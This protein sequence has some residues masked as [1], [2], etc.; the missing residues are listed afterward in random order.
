MEEALQDDVLVAGGAGV[1]YTP[2]TVGSA[3]R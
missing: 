1:V 2:E 3:G